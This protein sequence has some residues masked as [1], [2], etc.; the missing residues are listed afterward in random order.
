MTLGEHLEELRLRIILALIGLAAGMVVGL[1]FGNNILHYLRQPYEQIYASAELVALKPAEGFSCYLRVSLL[2]GLVLSSPWMFYQFWMFVS[3]G[4]YPRERRYVLF[5]VPFSSVLFIGGAA[6]FLKV[7]SVPVLKFFVDM[8]Q[9][10]D[11]KTQLTVSNYVGFMAS[12]MLI[13]GL[14]FQMPLAMLLMAKMGL[15]TTAGLNRARKF[16][17]AGIFIVAAIVTPPGPVVHLALALPMWALF[18]LG[19]LLCWLLAGRRKSV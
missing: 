8:N 14:A 6:F 2:A 19:V 9:W 3:A 4:L 7:A 17:I 5:A 10:L 11:V 18:E 15:V 13:F 16:V 1:V 12:L